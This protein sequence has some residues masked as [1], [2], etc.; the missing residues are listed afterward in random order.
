MLEGY[1][2]DRNGKITF[3]YDGTSDN[4]VGRTYV[5]G[6]DPNPLTKTASIVGLECY[7]INKK[8]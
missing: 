2:T 7:T 1:T 8:I 6:D 4:D 5:L 3:T